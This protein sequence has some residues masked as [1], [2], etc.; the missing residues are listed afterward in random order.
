MSLKEESSVP[1]G[2]SERDYDWRMDW[3]ASTVEK[4]GVYRG[5]PTV[6]H[7]AVGFVDVPEDV[8]LQVQPGLQS[9]T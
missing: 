8:Q 1:C 7:L 4:R 2:C 9:L 3:Q 6:Y 5:Q